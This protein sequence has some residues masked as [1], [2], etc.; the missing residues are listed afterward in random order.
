MSQKFYITPDGAKKLRDELNDLWRVTRPEV[1]K[2]VSEAAALGDRSEN[3]DYIYG[4]KRLREIDKRIRYLTKRLDNLE[5]VDRLPDDQEKVY[6]GAW[7]RLENEQG[8]LSEIRIVGSDEFDPKLGWISLES[9][10]AKSL[11][12]KSKETSIFLNLPDGQTEFYIV[13]VSYSPFEEAL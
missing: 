1:T 3:A 12:G 6:F 8:E 7:V 4:K 10:M 11:L 5:I 2:Q 9:P 13:D